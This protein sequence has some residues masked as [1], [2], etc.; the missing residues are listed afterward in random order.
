MR[1][2]RRQIPSM[3]ALFAFEAAG[4]LG[5]LS[6]ASEEL[7]VTPAAVSR[8][9]R[10][11]EDHLG[12]AL[13][14]R[15]GAGVVLSE[16]GRLLHDATSRAITQ[17]ESAVAEIE[18]RSKGVD[19]V[20]ISVSTAFTTHWLMPRMARFKADF[21]SVDL[22]FQLVMGPLSGPVDDVDFGMRFLRASET[23][24]GVFSIMPEVLIPISSPS[25]GASRSDGAEG[26]TL[27]KLSE[28]EPHAPQ[29]LLAGHD[30]AGA[31]PLIFADYAI[32][33]QAA[34]LGQGIAWG[35]LSV[36]GHWIRHGDLV[37][38]R[39]RCQ[40]TSRQCC[41]VQSS[42]RTP[43]PVAGQVRDWIIAEL[44]ND[45]REVSRMFP[46]LGIPP[47]LGPEG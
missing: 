30:L 9:M 29:N 13:F 14:R 31:N 39:P 43:R 34:L 8:M 35:W 18:D 38:A 4:R 16:D 45:Y 40:L 24:E 12:T 42:G 20:T 11:L 2:L 10:R 26:E 47:L 37:P 1:P 19:T 6:R 36:V 23:R 21:P 46:E 3:N 17:I 32:V 41:F 33:V 28:G 27:I 5:N 7:N 15:S 25:Y 22:R 44:Q